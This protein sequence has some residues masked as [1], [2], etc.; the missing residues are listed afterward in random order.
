MLTAARVL[1]TCGTTGLLL[2]GMV[3]G[4]AIGHYAPTGGQWLGEWMD[5]TLL[6]LI[7]LLLVGVRF[8]SLLKALRH[9]RFLGVVLLVNFVLIPAIGF[10]IASLFL[11]A[12]PLL[13][14]GL[15]IYFMSPCTDWFLGFTRLADGNVTLGTALIP[16]NMLVQLLLYPVFVFLFTRNVVEVD[17]TLIGSALLQWFVLPLA[18]ALAAQHALRL[19]MGSERFG[20]LLAWADRCTPLVL[21]LLVAQI[22]ADNIGVI[23]E[24]GRVFIWLLLAVFTFF[25]ITFLLG[26]AASRLARLAY[27]ERALLTMTTAARNA[28]LMLAVTM[29]ALP[30][31]PLV[32][33]AI[34][35][36]MLLEFPHLT[37]LRYLLLRSR[38]ASNRTAPV[39]GIIT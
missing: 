6:L 34:V 33:A 13:M 20:H 2:G 27:P 24:H 3:S 26:E 15:A 21:A 7:V 10:L 4:A 9:L 16:I 17:S 8:G 35:I 5:A 22:F 31:Q 12:H 32:Y 19:M 25:V 1:A 11:G 39:S 36:G 14:V 29:V 23:L 38:R 30:G 28:P 18:V 37:L